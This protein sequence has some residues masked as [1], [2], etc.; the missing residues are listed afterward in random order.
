[1]QGDS[2]SKIIGELA[3]MGALFF[4][5]VGL[6]DD[7]KALTT[8]KGLNGEESYRMLALLGVAT[9]G[10][11]KAIVKALEKA[12]DIV[13]L[14]N[15]AVAGSAEMAKLGDEIKQA[16]KLIGET[17]KTSKV[18]K[19]PRPGTLDD[20]QGALQATTDRCGRLCKT[21]VIEFGIEIA[22]HPD[23]LSLIEQIVKGDL[24]GT[25]TETLVEKIAK[26]SNYL[27]LSGKYGSNNGFDHVLIKA[28]DDGSVLILD[29]KQMKNMATKVEMN[30]AG[31]F[32][33]LSDEWI[34]QVVQNLGKS[35]KKP[36]M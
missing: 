32:P 1:M 21:K 30:A 22:K 20:L 35:A 23:D 16:E 31:G 15:K 4:P 17:T 7:V 29:S 5:P 9:S 10:E 24:G 36:Q 12:C 34:D 26:R 25:L 11:G 28:A 3:Y 6:S 13:E 8:G 19:V 14:A 27:S 2:N 33:Q 18:T